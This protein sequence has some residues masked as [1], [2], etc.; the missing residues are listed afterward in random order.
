M[1]NATQ[2][3]NAVLRSLRLAAGDEIVVL[4]HVYGAVRNTVRY[5]TERAGARMVEAEIPFP[6]PHADAIVANLR[7]ALTPRTRLAVLDHIT[8]GQCA[9][10]AAGSGWSRRAMRRACRCWSMVRTGRGRWRST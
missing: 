6:R 1:V 3:C 4:S 9:G 10:A 8:S 7:A 2:G 5:V